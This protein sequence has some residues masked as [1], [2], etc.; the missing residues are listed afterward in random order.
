MDGPE[1]K[2]TLRRSVRDAR[3]ALTP[4]QRLEASTAIT[5]RL[6]RL[7][8]LRTARVVLVYAAMPEEVD[9]EEAARDLRARGVVTLY[10]RVQG[11]DLALVP[12]TDIT[13]LVAGHRRI[14]EPQGPPADPAIVDAAL[15]PGVAFDL[16][17][18]RLGQGG[19]HYDR[20]LAT[21][22]ETCLRVG[23]CF[24]GQLVPRVPRAEH[25]EPVDLVLTERA[26]HHTGA[27][28]IR[29]DA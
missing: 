16:R 28:D 20:L 6:R 24:S 27:R 10:P 21:L 1:R 11:E 18:G 29:D 17:G 8:E 19:G 13:S 9:V 25:D 14:L 7:P 23:V 12:V 22:P 5:A 3:R 15:V 26:R 4:T 2:A